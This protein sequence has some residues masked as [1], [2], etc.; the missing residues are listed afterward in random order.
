MN[1]VGL[2]PAKKIPLR[3]KC[4]IETGTSH[5]ACTVVME[6][7]SG[8]FTSHTMPGLKSWDMGILPNHVAV[9]GVSSHILR[10]HTRAMIVRAISRKDCQRYFIPHISTN[11]ASSESKKRRFVPLNTRLLMKRY[12]ARNCDNG[13]IVCVER[14]VNSVTH[15][16]RYC[17]LVSLFDRTS[18]PLHS[19]NSEETAE[20]KRKKWNT[21]LVSDLFIILLCP[22]HFLLLCFLVLK[23]QKYNEMQEMRH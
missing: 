15:S 17:A 23:R 21:N 13:T 2:L 19:H 8:A 16:T 14:Y 18:H 7:N 11:F 12:Q 1:R 5:K 22:R 4:I 6:P 20:E 10:Q 9:P 3:S